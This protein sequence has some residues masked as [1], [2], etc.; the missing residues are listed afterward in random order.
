MDEDPNVNIADVFERGLSQE[1]PWSS[2]AMVHTD[3]ASVDTSPTGNAS[4]ERALVLYDPTKTPFVK[5][6]CPPE[7]SIVVKSDLL[8]GLKGKYPN[9][10]FKFYTIF[11]LALISV[12]CICF[13][14]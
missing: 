9:S 7:F 1:L 12:V 4:E 10:A 6:P 13:F 11:A 8:P 3:A 5:S 2:S 14:I